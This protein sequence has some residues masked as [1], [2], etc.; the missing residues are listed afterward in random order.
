VLTIY[1]AS[2]GVYEKLPQPLKLPP[3]PASA[4]EEDAFDFA[5][6]E[7][8]RLRGAGPMVQR[9]KHV[10]WL[11]PALTK[12]LRLVNITAEDETGVAY[13]YIA[14]MPAIRQWLVAVRLYEG[15]YYLLINQHNGRRTR[16]WSPPAVA[17]NGRHFVCGNSDVLARYEPNGLQLWVVENG[18][19]RL[20]WERQT[21]WGCTQPRWLDN[22]TILFEQD[23]FDNG[24]VDTRVVRLTVLP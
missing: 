11:Q 9:R 24:D 6:E 20:L 4:E 5:A 8:L 16:V 7:R 12:P 3:V 23:F 19:L 22:K 21:E 17:P 10:L 13:E 15:G 2:R 18:N 1:Q 14:S